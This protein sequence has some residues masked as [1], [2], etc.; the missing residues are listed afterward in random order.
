LTQISRNEL[1]LQLSRAS[2]T[3]NRWRNLRDRRIRER[4][5]AISDRNDR[6]TQKLRR[7]EQI[8]TKCRLFERWRIRAIVLN[9]K[10]ARASNAR[11]AR[12]FFC[13]WVDRYRNQVASRLAIAFFFVK[14]VII[15]FPNF[16]QKTLRQKISCGVFE[17]L[18]K[19]ECIEGASQVFFF[20]VNFV[21]PNLLR[22]FENK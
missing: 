12:N 8:L 16:Y 6:A 18:A 7:V 13:R 3:F 2:K 21:F 22:S 5:E 20:F 10:A 9:K 15:F 17:F 14:I 4:Q 19:L 11:R 1:K